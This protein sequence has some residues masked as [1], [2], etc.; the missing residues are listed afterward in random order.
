[1]GMANERSVLMRPPRRDL[2]SSITT[3]CPW[4][5]SCEAA[6]TPAM[7]PP[8]TTISKGA[9]AAFKCR[10]DAMAVAAPPI[11]PRLVIMF[12]LRPSIWAQEPRSG[13]QDLQTGREIF[14]KHNRPGKSP[15]RGGGPKGSASPAG[16]YHRSDGIGI[17]RPIAGYMEKL[18]C[19]EGFPSISIIWRFTK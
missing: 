9:L 18:I 5:A 17:G 13:F 14:C 1:M 19:R 16:S 7:P 10:A 15:G 11:I 2:A 6:A 8:M 3:W 4:E 12:R